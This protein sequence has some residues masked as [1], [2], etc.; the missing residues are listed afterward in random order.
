MRELRFSLVGCDAV[1]YENGDS[2]VFRK[3]AI[4]L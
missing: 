4:L 3:V 1:Q 2:K